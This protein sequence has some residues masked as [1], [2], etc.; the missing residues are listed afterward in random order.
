MCTSC[1]KVV[2]MC[3][4]VF[5]WLYSYRSIDVHASP[6]IQY[7]WR[8]TTRAVELTAILALA[9]NQ[10]TD[11]WASRGWG[12]EQHVLD[13]WAIAGRQYYKIIMDVRTAIAVYRTGFSLSDAALCKY[14][15]IGS[16]ILNENINSCNFSY[17]RYIIIIIVI[18]Y[19]WLLYSLTEHKH[20]TPCK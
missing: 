20:T 4:N 13:T 10:A 19:C 11:N 5:I 17:T 3:Y 14:I 16:I 6:T 7:C 18:F 12:G 8:H 15:F 1:K 9:T 2:S